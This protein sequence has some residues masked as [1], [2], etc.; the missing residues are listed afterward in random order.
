[1]GALFAPVKI[2]DMSKLV[3]APHTYGPSTYLQ[4]YFQA[5]MQQ[6]TFNAYGLREHAALTCA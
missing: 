5:N 2:N 6:P 1:M 4:K 3:Y